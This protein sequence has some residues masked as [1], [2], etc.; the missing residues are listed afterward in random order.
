MIV[1]S[2][3]QAEHE[4]TAIYQTLVDRF[5]RVSHLVIHTHGGE[6]LFSAQQSLLVR[7]LL[8]P[9]NCIIHWSDSEWLDPIYRIKVHEHDEELNHML[10]SN[11]HRGPFTFTTFGKSIQVRSKALAY[12]FAEGG[13]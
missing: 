10:K 5:I 6:L 8:T 3:I 11:K 4:A 13:C 2:H 9:Q 7:I 1:A 12:A